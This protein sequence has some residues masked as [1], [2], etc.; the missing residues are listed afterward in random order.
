MAI[1]TVYTIKD[2]KVVREFDMEYN[3]AISQFWGKAGYY[4]AR[5]GIKIPFPHRRV[6]LKDVRPQDQNQ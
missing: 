3:S 1:A 4:V 6:H 2:G 5:K